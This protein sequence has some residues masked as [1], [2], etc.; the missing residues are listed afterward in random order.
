M[1]MWSFVRTIVQHR[2]GSSVQRFEAMVRPHLDSL[3]RLAYRLTGSPDDAE[4]LVQ[5]LLLKLVPQEARMVEVEQLGPWLARSLYYL[6]VDQTRHRSN[7]P[8]DRADSEG[9][10]ALLE[11]PA[12][13]ADQPFEF[14]A[15]MLTQQRIADA[16]RRLPDEQR[17][18]IAWHDIE[19]YTL[20][21]LAVQHGIPLGTLKSRLHR[22][23]ARLKGMLMQP[24][25]PIER[26][27]K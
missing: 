5:A 16:L 9:E 20:E 10:E 26:V 2:S 23:R 21:E 12:D 27:R 19:G 7:S 3:Y 24:L 6:F 22:A 17:A 18:L 25:A 14:A 1:P 15:R 8:L 11:L 13:E 4:D